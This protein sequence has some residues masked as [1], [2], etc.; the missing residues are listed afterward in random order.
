M[1]LPYGYKDATPHRAT[2]STEV[3]NQSGKP[4]VGS[5]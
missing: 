5:R 1:P 3:G 4:F 2:L